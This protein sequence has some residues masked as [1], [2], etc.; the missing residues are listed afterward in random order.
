MA[1]E[2]RT[3]GTIDGVADLISEARLEGEV[4]A[5]NHAG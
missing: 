1:T 5:S 4:P 2:P 3:T